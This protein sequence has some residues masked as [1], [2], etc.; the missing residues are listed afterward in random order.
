MREAVLGI[1][2]GGSKTLLAVV[3]RSGELLQLHR[4]PG[5]AP[6]ADAAWRTALLD[7]CRR[8]DRSALTLAA[9]TVALPGHGQIAAISREQ[10]RLVVELL[11]DRTFVIHDAQAAF[12]GAFPDRFGVLLL[13]GTG[14][15]ALAGT[16][17]KPVVQIG[18]W[19]DAFGDEGSAYW[20]GCEA[21]R[22][23]SR[24][25]DG[26]SPRDGFAEALIARVLPGAPADRESLMSWVYGDADRR[27]RVAAVANHVDVLATQGSSSSALGLLQRAADQLAELV[28]VARLR[29]D[30]PRLRWS[31]SGGVSR[32]S[33]IRRALE[34]RLE[35][36]RVAPALP[37][38]GGAV[39]DAAERAGWSVDQAWCSRLRAG[40][41]RHD[42]A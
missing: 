35:T 38:V 39:L 31:S 20:I 36:P 18:G 10:E 32:S 25:L 14:S 8:L 21:L 40:L 34:R 17:A 1:D 26:R 5:I 41:E 23:V 19:S 3:D 37:P 2:G 22:V 9:A 7:A 4:A 27:A 16:A 29:L 24:Q 42:P 11:G 12:I 28:V 30:E 33:A 6:M 13:A 15:I